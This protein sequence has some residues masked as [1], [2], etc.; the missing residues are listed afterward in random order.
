[1]HVNLRIAIIGCCLA[2]VACATAAA[3]DMP[4]DL[5]FHEWSV[6][7]GEPQAKQMNAHLLHPSAMPWVVDT[8]RCR[9]HEGDKPEPSPLS[10]LTAY[11]TPNE[12]G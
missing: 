1:M 2:L 3:A 5:E 9:R 11:G 6:W 7:I 4:E 10:M 8:E 12:A